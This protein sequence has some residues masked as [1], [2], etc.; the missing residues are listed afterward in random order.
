[1]NRVLY[2]FLF[3]LL[4]C[5]FDVPDNKSSLIALLTN[6]AS[7]STIEYIFSQFFS[8]YYLLSFLS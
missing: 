5:Q 8:I 6:P 3:A 7:S 4:M 1:M 2:V